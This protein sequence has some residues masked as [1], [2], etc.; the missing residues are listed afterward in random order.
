MKNQLATLYLVLRDFVEPLRRRLDS[1]EG[2]EFLFY[3]YGWTVTLDEATFN[4]IQQA[5][6]IRQPLEQ[7]LDL[8]Q[9]LQEKLDANPEAEL[10]AAEILS[11]IEASGA[12][13]RAMAA[14]EIGGISGLP[15]PL[16]E[17]AFWENL[18]EHLFD[19]LLE[20]YLR[21]FHP[22]FYLILRLWGVIRVDQ[23]L[24]TEPFRKS[25]REGVS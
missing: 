12:L 10:D 17:A 14:F 1:L 16:N 18:S 7:F 13:I 6:A 2:L 19:D 15:A 3:R 11:L 9:Q 5:A 20:E 22:A 21:V 23:V 4:Q 8:A 25:Y 24:L